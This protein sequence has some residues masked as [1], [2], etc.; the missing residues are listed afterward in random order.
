M[1]LRPGYIVLMGLAVFIRRVLID[2][3]LMLV[4]FGV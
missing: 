4:G 2:V 3:Y 1:E